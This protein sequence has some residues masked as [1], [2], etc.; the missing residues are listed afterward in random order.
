M[1]SA[2]QL[3]FAYNTKTVFNYPDITC[4]KD[5]P[6]LITGKSG[7][8]KTTLLHL[9][10][11]LLRPAGG[12]LIIDGTDTTLLRDKR[13]D[14][15]RG[16]HIGIVYQSSHFMRALNVMDNILLPRFFTQATTDSGR[17]VLLAERLQIDHLLHKRPAELSNGEQQRVS[18]ARALINN[19][20]LLLADEP[21]SSLDDENTTRVV[22]LLKEQA[23]ISQAMLI[24]VSHD[25]RLKLHFSNQVYLAG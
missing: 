14:K 13:L 11:C 25:A 3:Q 1:L 17:A 10:G 5:T 4:N 12:K 7:T 2:L 16:R 23:A 20:Q 6:V 8:G 24:V 19:P 9:L 21:T 15:F 22:Q 18:I